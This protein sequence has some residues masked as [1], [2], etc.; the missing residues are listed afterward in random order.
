MSGLW[1]QQ[2]RGILRLELRKNLLGM[3]ALPVYLLAGAPLAV[4]AIFMIVSIFAGVT[5]DLKGY[6]GASMFFSVLFQFILRFPIYVA[7]VWVFMNLFRGEVLDRSLHYYFL[8]P[9]RR[10]VLVA[11][12]FISAWLTTTILFVGSTT[13][14]FVTVFAFLG[15]AGGSGPALGGPALGQLTAYLGVTILACL[16]YGAVFMLVGQF[17]RNPIIPAL[18]IF[19][20]EGANSVLP[21]LLK[22]LSVIFYLQSLYPVPPDHG[23]ISIIAEPV[24]PWLG[25]PGLILFSALTLALSGLR[26]RHMEISYASD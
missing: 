12:K 5:E 18:I 10:E 4:V 14:C 9:V 24:S 19:V 3:R 6:F 22:K 17:F 23:T 15:A 25:V 20:W 1:T 13:I 16:G 2:V 21:A 11:G 26:I 7:C 8:T